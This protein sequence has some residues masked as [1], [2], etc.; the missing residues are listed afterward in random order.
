M[1]HTGKQALSLTLNPLCA[2]FTMLTFVL[3]GDFM[4]WP[5]RT[6]ILTS[7]DSCWLHMK[8]QR[9][10]RH[11]SAFTPRLWQWAESLA[12][13]EPSPTLS[14]VIGTT[15]MS[16][17]H[18]SVDIFPKGSLLLSDLLTEL[19]CGTLR[20]LFVPRLLNLMLS[21]ARG[22]CWCPSKHCECWNPAWRIKPVCKGLLPTQHQDSACRFIAFLMKEG[23]LWKK[24][25]VYLRAI[26]HSTVKPTCVIVETEFKWSNSCKLLLVLG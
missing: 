3:S 5:T 11:V 23:N 7:H 26:Q 17:T 6:A 20:A 24:I 22:P 8:F 18:L 2:N 4:S 19:V 15:E 1:Y 9:H 12:L 13:C 25:M 16:L 10:R 21:L 14:S